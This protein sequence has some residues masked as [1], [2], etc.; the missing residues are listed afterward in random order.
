MRCAPC[1]SLSSFASL[2]AVCSLVTGG[3]TAGAVRAS[4]QAR[5]TVAGMSP[6]TPMSGSTLTLRGSGLDT[7]SISLILYA[8]DR[9]AQISSWQLQ[10]MIYYRTAQELRVQL[11]SFG[12]A[13]V[14][15]GNYTLHLE[16]I[17]RTGS[18]TTIEL[19]LTITAG[20]STTLRT[21][22]LVKDKTQLTA[23]GAVP[24][25]QCTLN[26]ADKQTIKTA[27]TTYYPYWISRLTYGR[28]K[29]EPTVVYSD[30]PLTHVS[31]QGSGFWPAPA[32]VKSD[33]NRYVPAGQYDVVFIYWKGI[34]DKTGKQVPGI[35]TG[36]GRGPS[37]D[38]NKTGYATINYATADHWTQNAE[39][40]EYFTHEMLHGL[41]QFYGSKPGVALPT[42]ADTPLHSNGN[43]NYNVRF[44]NRD[45]TLGGWKHWYEAF[46]NG[47]VRDNKSGVWLGLGET[48]WHYGTPREAAR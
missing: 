42:G 32:D 40:T 1:P 30:M 34:D 14:P 38:T 37:A 4:A 17:P 22:L 15:A 21:L 24:A 16:L 9:G 18:D 27:F 10:G 45:A 2:L 41:E 31:P 29:I 8:K 12:G 33:L 48:A 46:I 47:K 39:T 26:E 36:W 25:V 6:S 7:P 43:A 5:P 35:N 23:S 3:I 19:P 44:H 13:P 11:A 28:I 20:K